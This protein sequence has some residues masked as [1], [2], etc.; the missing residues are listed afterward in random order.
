MSERRK[1]PD[2]KR[3]ER[4]LALARERAVWR[5]AKMHPTTYRALYEEELSKG[6][7]A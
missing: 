1:E 4:D 3:R 5:L 6:G 2:K 7:V